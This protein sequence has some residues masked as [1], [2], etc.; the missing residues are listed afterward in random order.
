MTGLYLRCLREATGTRLEDAASAAGVSTSAVSQ[1]ERAQSS[2]RADALRTLLLLYGVSGEHMNF[3]VGTLPPQGYVRSS[4]AEQGETGRAP[5]DCWADVAGGE[6]TARYIAVMRME[7]ELIQF[8]RVIPAGLRTQAYE[9][10]VLDPSVCTIPDEPVLG[11]PSWVHRVRWAEEQR[12][13]VVLDETVLTRGSR[14]SEV[15]A[16]QLRHLADL[17]SREGA[18]GRGL[19]VRILSMSSVLLFVHTIGSVAEVNLHGH[20]MVARVGFVPSYETGSCATQTI[21]AGLREAADAACNRDET[22]DRLVCAADAMQGTD[23]P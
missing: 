13:I 7:S 12:R 10:A 2:I 14:Q 15:V 5:H 17:V 18:E 21:S 19:S 22:Y 11:L 3:L 4:G 6:A 16:G 9:R 8:C 23:T 1:W 20:R